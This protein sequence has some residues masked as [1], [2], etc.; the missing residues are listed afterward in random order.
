METKRKMECALCEEVIDVVR[1]VVLRPKSSCIIC[2]TLGPS[3]G[4]RS[5]A[6]DPFRQS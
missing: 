5:S 3:H 2:W 6:F 1:R 4:P